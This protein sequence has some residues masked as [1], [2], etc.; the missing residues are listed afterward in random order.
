MFFL[1]AEQQGTA[2]QL[3]YRFVIKNLPQKTSLEKIG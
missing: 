3:S 1:V 2:Q